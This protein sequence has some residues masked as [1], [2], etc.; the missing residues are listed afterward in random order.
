MVG[1]EQSHA[2]DASE[3]GAPP[4]LGVLIVAENASLSLGG[5]AY[6]SVQWF[7]ELLRAGVDVHLLVHARAR[8]ELDRS[9]AEF[10]DRIHYVPDVFLQ[11]I[12]WEL[13]KLL[14]PRIGDFTSGWLVHLITQFR[15]RPVARRLIRQYEIGVVHEPSPVSPRLPSMMYGLGVP[16]VIGPMNGNMTYPPRHRPRRAFAEQAFVSLARGVAGLANTLIPGKRR[17]DVL[18]VANE[19]TRSALP[20]GYGGK[21]E[22]L[23]ENGVDPDLWQHPGDLPVPS[24]PGLRLAFVGRLMDWKG[25]DLVLD[26]LAEVRR[27]MPSAELWIIGDGPERARL[28]A[29]AA[30]LGVSGAVTFHGWVSREDCARLLSQ[31]DILVFPSVLECGGAAVLEA[32]AL[33]LAVV[34][35]NWGGPSDY[36]AGGIGVLIEPA[37]RRETV[38]GLVEAVLS[39]TPGRRQELG[40]AAQRRIAAQY[41]WPAK[42]RRILDIYRSVYRFPDDVP[43]QERQ[44]PSPDRPACRP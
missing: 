16:V 30:A 37:G 13:G 22:I 6:L 10:A 19:R 38:A 26:V 33:G 12:L 21:V 11:R 8:R 43:V 17:A 44:A 9:L 32:M 31:S 29:R 42:V 34:A 23:C 5:E 39:L 7:R 20:S 18:L 40:E 3:V 14:P 15:Q 41:S 1:A 28:R 36:L 25:A 27:Q 2:Q 4:R 35:L 24:A